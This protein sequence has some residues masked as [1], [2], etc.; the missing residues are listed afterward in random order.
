MKNTYPE[1]NSVH[2]YFELEDLEKWNE[3]DISNFLENLSETKHKDNEIQI[4]L[5]IYNSYL[6]KGEND[7]ADFYRN[8]IQELFPLYSESLQKV[9]DSLEKN[10]LAV[11][12]LIKTIKKQL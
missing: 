8:K 4:C 2:L 3:S 12:E 10:R 1:S 11:Y 9:V 5:N 7:K 6:E